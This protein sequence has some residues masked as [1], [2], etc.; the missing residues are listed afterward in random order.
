[1]IE[2]KVTRGLWYPHT[3]F[4]WFGKDKRLPPSMYNQIFES[5]QPYD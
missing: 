2:L 4:N 1:M 3:K 5:A